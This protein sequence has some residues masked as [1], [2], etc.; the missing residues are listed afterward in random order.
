MFNG[1]AKHILQCRR[2]SLGSA[3]YQQRYT[4]GKRAH[5]RVQRNF[6]QF[7]Y[8]CAEFSYDQQS[9]KQHCQSHLDHLR[10]RCGLMKFRYTLVAPAF[11]PFCLGD[12]SKEPDERFQQWMQ[13]PTLWN[14]ID[15]HL[16]MFESDS[17]IPCPHPLC[18]Q[19]SYASKT[20][21]RRHLY[22]GHSLD[23][24]RPNCLAR[25]RKAEEQAEI[26]ANTVSEFKV[27][28]MN[29]CAE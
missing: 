15:S 3:P 8:L 11:C 20:S 1:R 5:R 18:D 27:Q 19:H 2:K 21:L 25:K 26:S 29:N 7:C 4:N 22:D 16:L 28:K 10:P 23:E 13:K 9:W 14:H 17:A 6:V 12:E 24:P